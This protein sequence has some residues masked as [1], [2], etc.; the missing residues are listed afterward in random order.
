VPAVSVKAASFMSAE[1]SSPWSTTTLSRL[2]LGPLP[3]AV[4]LPGVSRAPG[5]GEVVMSPRLAEFVDAGSGL[6]Q[7]FDGYERIEQIAPEGL[8]SPA[9]LRAIVG[10]SASSRALEPSEGLGQPSPP[11]TGNTAV[12]T[13]LL[14]LCGVLVLSPVALLVAIATR[15]SAR[16]QDE[17][18]ALLK[19]LGMSEASRRSMVVA[20]T[21]IV[22][23]PGAAA[24]VVAFLLISRQMKQLP[25][26]QVGIYPSDLAMSPLS[27]ITVFITT[28]S[29]TAL[30]AFASVPK[31]ASNVTT[32]GDHIPRR[33]IAGLILLALGIT[34]VGVL[35]FVAG[36]LNSSS[37]VQ[38]VL[39]ISLVVMTGLP[40]G[41]PVAVQRLSG[42]VAA[43]RERVHMLIAA[44]WLEDDPGVATRVAA[45]AS[46]C[47]LCIGVAMPMASLLS[48]DASATEDRLVGSSRIAVVVSD[49]DRNL[50]A[51]ALAAAVPG[52]TALPILN[53]RARGSTV[54]ALIAT[55]DDLRAFSEPTGCSGRIQWLSTSSVDIRYKIPGQ[56][57]RAS[58]RGSTLRLPPPEEVM[59]MPLH[60]SLDGALV[61]PPGRMPLSDSPLLGRVVVGIQVAADEDA[62]AAAAANLSQGAEVDSGYISWISQASRFAPHV[63]VI[64]LSVGVTLALTMLSFTVA[65]M[66]DSAARSRR[67][68]MLAILGASRR[69][70]ESAQGVTALLP[71]VAGVTLALVC[72]LVIRRTFLLVD[73]RSGVPLGYYAILWF[74][75]VTVGLVQTV[76]GVR[77]SRR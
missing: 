58:I 14:W 5:P 10:V 59:D 27:V 7:Y 28:G 77:S 76:I 46:V 55:C 49:P 18:F 45:G 64:A 72:A 3:E 34:G 24:G 68:R 15:Y 20:E 75:T 11:V 16:D 38:L 36:V 4:S 21:L 33:R 31:A 70:Q 43:K 71:L 65:T 61:V 60:P 32:H 56:A 74:G 30:V 8:T 37:M 25:F 40:L 26:T 51:Q 19:L 1:V 50:T 22:T 47:V 69:V 9:E 23:F 2:L 52:S 73:A 39:V 48:G 12:A 44:R 35:P 57:E 6:A 17:R 53:M 67:S 41:M 54:Q 66:G 29:V 63:K 62:L 13:A 42:R